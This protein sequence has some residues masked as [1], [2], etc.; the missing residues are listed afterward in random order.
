MANKTAM[1]QLIIKVNLM[2]KHGGDIDLLPVVSHAMNLLAE[3]KKQ[4]TQAH[5]SGQFS[6]DGKDPSISESLAYFVTTYPQ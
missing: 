5:Q 1:A 6:A 4:I 2:I 3:E